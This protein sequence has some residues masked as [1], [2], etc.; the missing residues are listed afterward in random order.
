MNTLPTHGI[1]CQIFRWSLGDCSR[2][3]LSAHVNTVTLLD[4]A[5]EGPVEPSADAPAVRLVRRTLR[6]REYV[7]AEPVEPC[8]PSACRM[9]GG[10]YIAGD[11]RFTAAVNNGGY[12]VSLH[13][14]HET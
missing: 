9:F 8:P 5:I 1:R 11:S 14:R 4:P 13:D 2:G 10:T 3:G 12:P 7:H 6:G